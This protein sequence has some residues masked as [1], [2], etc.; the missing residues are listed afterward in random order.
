[1][2]CKITLTCCV[3][4]RSLPSPLPPVISEWVE[5]GSCQMLGCN[6]LL[7]SIASRDDSNATD[8]FILTETGIQLVRVG[9]V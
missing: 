7:S 9:L 8:Q 6:P 3:M 5:E 2:K 1:M 4:V